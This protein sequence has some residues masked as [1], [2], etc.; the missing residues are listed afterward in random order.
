MNIGFPLSHD[1]SSLQPRGGRG[2]AAPQP[3]SQIH[4]T[5]THKPANSVLLLLLV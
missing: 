4:Y 2:V 5:A 1:L 3:P